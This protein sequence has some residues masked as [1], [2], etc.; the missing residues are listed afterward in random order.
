MVTPAATKP[1]TPKGRAHRATKLVGIGKPRLATGLQTLPGITIRADPTKTA[2]RSGEYRGQR[3]HIYEAIDYTGLYIIV[4]AASCITVNW[5]F[6]I[7]F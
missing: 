6:R 3:L 4:M 5:L 7:D 1:K 2:K